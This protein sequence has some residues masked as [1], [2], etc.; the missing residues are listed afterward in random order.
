LI[1]PYFSFFN[2]SKRRA[3]AA[4]RFF[5]DCCRACDGASFSQSVSLSCFVLLPVDQHSTQI[6]VAGMGPAE[7]EQLLLQ[8]QC[9]LEDKTTRTGETTH[10]MPLLS[11]RPQFKPISLQTNLDRPLFAFC[12]P[13][14]ASLTQLDS[15]FNSQFL[16]IQFLRCPEGIAYSRHRAVHPPA[17]MPRLFALAW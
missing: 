2:E 14:P 1:R 4:S 5:K 6:L 13:H 3:H 15:G 11:V 9:T 8:G 10:L 12:S 17:S 16:E 7:F